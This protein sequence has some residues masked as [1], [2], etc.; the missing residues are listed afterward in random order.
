MLTEALLAWEQEAAAYWDSVIRSPHF[1]ALVS[2]HLTTMLEAR[3]QLEL[4]LETQTRLAALEQRLDDLAARI[5][6]MEDR[7]A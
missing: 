4:A 7:L 1:L 6:Q 5:D 2:R 3:Q